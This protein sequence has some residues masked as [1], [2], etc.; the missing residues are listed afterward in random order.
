[1]NRATTPVVSVIVPAFENPEGLRRC[2]APLTAQ[3]YPADRYDVLVVDN[4][5]RTD[6]SGV[7]GAFPRVRLEREPRPGS[8]AARNCGI[9]ATTSEAL[10]FIDSDCVPASDW[11]E[12]GIERLVA[13]PDCGFVA[14]KVELFFRDPERP[15]SSELYDFL[16]MGFHQDRHVKAGWGGVGNLFTWRTVFDAVGRFDASLMSGGDVEWGR[17]VSARGYARAYCAEARAGH[18]ARDSLDATLRRAVRV[19]GGRWALKGQ[20]GV[21]AGSRLVD[22][23]RSVTPAVGFY[24]RVMGDARLPRLRDRARVVGVA[25]AVKY[26]E[27]GELLRLA[28]GGAPR[29]E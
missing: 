12:R 6:L 26:A 16:V 29:R 1:M 15:T 22:L 17:R 8:Y 3:T 13:T 9:A 18:P 21:S 27:A 25:L 10:A 11:L 23:A 4:G 2:L 5:S 28:F 19:A 7:T 24:A 14:G 20:Q